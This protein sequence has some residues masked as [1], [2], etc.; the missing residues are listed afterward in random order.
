[1]ERWKGA[2]D[3]SKKELEEGGESLSAHDKRQLEKVRRWQVVV[4]MD[5]T[6]SAI[7]QQ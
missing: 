5:S 2:R 6:C 7:L 1:M 3:Q 4:M